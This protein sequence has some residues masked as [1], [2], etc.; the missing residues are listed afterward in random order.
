MSEF[1]HGVFV[2]KVRLS[3]D[4]VHAGVGPEERH[5]NSKSIPRGDKVVVPFNS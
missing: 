3:S 4:G 1:C 5:E 2:E